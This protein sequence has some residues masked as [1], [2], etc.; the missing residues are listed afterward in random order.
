MAGTIL[1]YLKDFGD[2][3]L[4]EKAFNEVDALI[5]C[6]LAYLKFD[7]LVPNVNYDVPPVELKWI[8]SNPQKEDLFSDERYEKVNREL[9]GAVTKSRRF[10]G[11]RVG[12]YVNLLEKDWET[13]F[14]AVTFYLQDG[15]AFLAFRG[16]DESLVGWKEDFNM[17]F[18]SPIPSQHCALKYFYIMAGRFQ[19]SLLLGGHSKG[20]N[21]ATFAA[22]NCDP[23]LQKR[24]QKIYNMD[25]P[26]FRPEILRGN[27][28]DGIR[29]RRIKILPRS[30][31]IGM[32]FEQEG[33]Y[34][35]V[36][37]SKRGIFQHDPFSWLVEEDHFLEAEGLREGWAFFDQTIN[38]WI[39][40]L[41]RDERKAFISALFQ[42]LE[43]SQARDL[44]E[45]GG[46]LRR[47]MHGMA[48]TMKNMDAA[49]AKMME[50]MLK[51][52]LEIAG[53]KALKELGSRIIREKSPQ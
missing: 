53:T 18:L 40:S 35:V 33:D 36:E 50:A 47:S 26:G 39:T 28:Y 12:A 37:S 43:G 24:I 25:G 19:G 23:G 31:V 13:Q 3:S 29:N 11:L 30:S 2:Y 5:L 49:T 1:T 38:E 4:K 9:F 48:K 34:H 44:I 45:L 7:D 20:G 41:T 21:L 6:E 46:D 22:M 32:L 14:S 27:A 52:F 10:G 16:T 51:R 15:S 8:A 17:T 42:I